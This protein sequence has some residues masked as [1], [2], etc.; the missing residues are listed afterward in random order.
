MEYVLIFGYF[1][2]AAFQPYTVF[3]ILGKGERGGGRENILYSDV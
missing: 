1:H 2:T 3:M